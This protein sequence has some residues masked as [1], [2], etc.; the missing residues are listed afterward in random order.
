[1]KAWHFSE[2]AYP[3]LPPADSYPS[4]RVTLPNKHYDPEKGAALYDR[5]IDEWLIAEDEGLEIMLNEHHQTATCVD[6]AAPLVMAALARLS[7]KAR[8]LILGNPIANR[9]QPVRVAEEMAMV[10]VLSR[11]RVESGFVRGV[12]YEISP[13]NSN[14]VRM[15]ERFWEALD[16]IVK[17]WTSHD[18]PVSHEGRF[19]HHRNINIW[20]RPYQNPHPPVWISTTSAGGA[21]AVGAR[22][23]VQAT[24]LTGFKETRKIY[25][26]YR[27]G[28]REAGRGQD[29]PIDR[30]AYAAL[31]YVGKTE[32]E[33]RAGAEKLLWY[34]TAN[35]V[36]PQFANPP[37]YVPVPANVAI[38]R[39]AEH[40]LSEFAKGASVDGAIKA[41]FM[42]A[43]TPDQ[44]YR[45]F[46]RHYDYVG[47]YGHL[48]IMGQAGH[49]DHDD[50]VA[51]IRNFAR[52]VYPRLKEEF[53]DTTVSGTF[54]D[55]PPEP[56]ADAMPKGGGE[57]GAAEKGGVMTPLGAARG[58]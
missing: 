19:F 23:Y 40:P 3:Y 6:P 47:G 18:G 28:W 25:E 32:A 26:S 35:K 15:N 50:T 8:L 41:G 46:K 14:P 44:V 22:G 11:G 54:G 2:N 30:L 56:P 43:G 57:K 1:M 12:P 45:Q 42:M 31:V 53:P 4:I 21:K 55:V 27:A 5:F 37:G 24:F 10:D 13:A 17:A 33:A 20:P 9:R 39:G 58:A 52:E 49:L 36:A 34:V 29:V 16:L 38:L 48:L 51:G 7:K